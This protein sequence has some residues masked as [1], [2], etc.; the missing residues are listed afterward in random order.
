ME[1]L[2]K[3]RDSRRRRRRAQTPSGAAAA[4]ALM[5]AGMH[6]AISRSSCV[7]YLLRLLMAR[8]SAS[9]TI[10]HTRIATGTFKS[11]AICRR[12]AAC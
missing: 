3:K 11:A 1:F 8:P 7:R 10:G 5:A 4:A 6:D 9:R 2:A 12:T